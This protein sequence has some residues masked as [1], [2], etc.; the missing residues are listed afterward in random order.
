MNDLKLSEESKLLE[1]KRKRFI[2]MENDFDD[3]G[4]YND[5]LNEYEENEQYNKKRKKSFNIFD[6]DE[7]DFEKIYENIVNNENKINSKE[8]EEI[9][10]KKFIK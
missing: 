6:E 1:K 3:T 8:N 4:Y 9:N 5:D 2:S 7:A 10:Y